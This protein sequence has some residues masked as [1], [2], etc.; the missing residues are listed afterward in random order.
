MN[1]S[2]GGEGWAGSALLL[3]LN[4]WVISSLTLLLQL[5]A[6]YF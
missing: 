5:K 2:H 6:I 1:E 3:P 4:D